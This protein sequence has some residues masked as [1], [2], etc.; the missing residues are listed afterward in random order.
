[1][2]EEHKYHDERGRGR[3]RTIARTQKNK[4]QLRDS[5]SASRCVCDRTRVSLKKRNVGRLA[6]QW[7]RGVCRRETK[8]FGDLH[9]PCLRGWKWRNEMKVGVGKHWSFSHTSCLCSTVLY[10]CDYRAHRNDPERNEKADGL[11]L[12]CRL[13]CGAGV[14]S[15]SSGDG[16]TARRGPGTKG[17]SEQRVAQL[18]GQ[19]KNREEA[20]FTKEERACDRKAVQ[21]R[22]MSG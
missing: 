4:H 9:R 12:G 11:A 17:G 3:L 19:K 7:C 18:T 2:D 21:I 10:A 14:S 13:H 6:I 8:Y 20:R 1:M 16:G 22:C 5:R 15:P